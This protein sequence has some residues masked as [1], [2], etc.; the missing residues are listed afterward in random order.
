MTDNIEFVTGLVI[1]KPHENAPDF[2][3]C[4]LSIKRDE[5]I[6]WLTAKNGL[7]VNVQIKESR[8]GNWYAAVDNWKPNKK[9]DDDVPF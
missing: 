1:K 6:K 3:K 5:L 7:W 8:N 2:V 9:T 4:G